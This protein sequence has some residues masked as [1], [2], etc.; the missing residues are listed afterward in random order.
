M[1]N[2]RGKFYDFTEEQLRNT[3]DR[4]IENIQGLL[5]SAQRLLEDK[6]TVQHALGLYM[7]AIEEYGKAH[8]LK[9]HLA[10]NKNHILIPRWIFGVGNP[11]NNTSH[12]EKLREG[13]RNLP[14]DCKKL[15]NSLIFHENLSLFP[16]RADCQNSDPFDLGNCASAFFWY[17]YL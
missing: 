15:T 2:N 5:K 11:P 4:C 7:Y 1:V 10:A 3:I 13:F 17:L 14:Q 8:L 6:S 12:N 9:S 16:S